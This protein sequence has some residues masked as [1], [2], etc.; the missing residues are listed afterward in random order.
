MANPVEV[1]IKENDVWLSFTSS[2]GKTGAISL[3]SLSEKRGGIVGAAIREWAAET[4]AG[5]RHYHVGPGDTCGQC[6]FDIRNTLHKRV[7]E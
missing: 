7:G 6:G 3:A 5:A 4:I 2:S 1:L